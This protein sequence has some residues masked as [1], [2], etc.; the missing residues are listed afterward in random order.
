MKCIKSCAVNKVARF[1][2]VQCLFISCYHRH[3]RT[4][5]SLWGFY[6]ANKQFPEKDE[7]PKIFSGDTII[8]HNSVRKRSEKFLEPGVELMLYVNFI[9]SMS[10]EETIRF[11]V[12]LVL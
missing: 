6:V 2:N 7:N 10:L 8:K 1:K 9:R 12:N 3:S 11:R 4:E 5:Y